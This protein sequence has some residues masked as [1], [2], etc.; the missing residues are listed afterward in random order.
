MVQADMVVVIGSSLKVAPV[1]EILKSIPDQ[2]PQILINKETL[3]HLQGHFDV[4]F[5]GDADTI[6]NVFSTALSWSLSQ[7]TT[8]PTSSSSPAYRF[9]PPNVYL[10]LDEDDPPCP[11]PGSLFP[12]TELTR[13][14]KLD[15]NDTLEETE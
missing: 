3:P 10:F 13:K 5:I 8:H 12:T 1:S 4:E 11:S 9:Q 7:H 14:R 2:V 6:V 15:S